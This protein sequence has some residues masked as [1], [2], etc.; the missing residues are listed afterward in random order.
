MTKRWTPVGLGMAMIAM[1]VSSTSQAQA[2]QREISPLSKSLAA[3]AELRVKNGDLA[4]GADLYESALAA[5]PANRDAYLALAAIARAQKLPGR[6][7]LLYRAAAAGNPRDVSALAGEGEALVEQG[8]LALAK[9]RL[10]LAE[11]HCAKPCAALEPLRSA[12]SR[13]AGVMPTAAVTPQ[14]TGAVE[15]Q[16]Q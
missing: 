12:L 2:P 1:A 7:I 10:A 4:T 15:P 16:R 3:E 8:A 5:D 13:A 11:A 9:D 6:A 14:A